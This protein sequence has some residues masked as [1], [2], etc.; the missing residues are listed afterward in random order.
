MTPRTT[1]IVGFV[2]GI[3]T[4]AVATWSLGPSAAE[5]PRLTSGNIIDFDERVRTIVER[6][7][8]VGAGTSMAHIACHYDAN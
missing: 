3:L 8:I 5:R 7:V 4:G 1:L 2:V 6:C